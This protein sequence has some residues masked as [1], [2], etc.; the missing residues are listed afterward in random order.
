MKKKIGSALVL[1]G[2][3]LVP[4]SS[5][6]STSSTVNL[7]YYDNARPIEEYSRIQLDSSELTIV[8]FDGEIPPIGFRLA[9][10]TLVLPAGE[11]SFVLFFGRETSSANRT[12]SYTSRIPFYGNFAP[13]R[14]Y[15]IYANMSGNKV[16][17]FMEDYTDVTE[18]ELTARTSRSFAQK[19]IQ[20]RTNSANDLRAASEKKL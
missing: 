13:N 8:E 15:Y 7:Q 12:T 5:C 1:I 16:S 17:V 11:H 3:L 10:N 19:I 6:T 14:F 2:F 4:F 20:K 18:E 9:K